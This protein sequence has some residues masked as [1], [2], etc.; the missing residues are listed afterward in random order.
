MAKE[1]HFSIFKGSSWYGKKL[2]LRP[3]LKLCNVFAGNI[4]KDTQ[5]HDFFVERTEITWQKDT[6]GRKL[7]E[8]RKKKSV[9]KPKHIH[10]IKIYT[11]VSKG[12]SWQ[13]KKKTPVTWKTDWEIF[14]ERLIVNLEVF[15]CQQ[16]NS[17][18]YSQWI[19]PS[20]KNVH[21]EF[22]TCNQN[23]SK[24]I[25]RIYTNIFWNA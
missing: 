2:S 5:G 1:H 8:M 15:D 17:T 4:Q 14:P 12:Q 10:G 16:R 13:K 11:E 9:Q 18:Q 19:L 20:S 22:L 6:N 23:S 21:V 7:I 25:R 24:I 3:T